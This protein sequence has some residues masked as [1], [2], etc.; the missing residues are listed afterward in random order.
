MRSATLRT[1]A[2]TLMVCALSHA[3]HA[4]AQLWGRIK[5]HAKQSLDEETAKVSEH[6]VEESN[7]T[8]DSA[9]ASTG[10]IADT[11]V[12]KVATV[13][14]SATTRATRAVMD[15]IR[16]GST[17]RRKVD[18]VAGRP[19]DWEI[20]F[21]GNSDQLQPS[22]EP[23]LESL[24][25]TIESTPGTFLLEGHVDQGADA[26]GAQS[27][28]ERRA[29]AVKAWLAAAGVPAN[30]LLTVGYGATRPVPAVSTSGPAPSNARIEVVRLQ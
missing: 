3:T 1:L 16:D 26:V 27:L 25:Q 2:A 8:V 11:V 14:D 18:L 19:V 20:R 22:A 6:I 17:D 30:R 29:Q 23:Y 12:G 5:D 13:L 28:S 15:G 4:E 7:S 9:L 10:R 21:V 24:S